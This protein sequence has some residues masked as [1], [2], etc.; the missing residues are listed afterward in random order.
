M[1]VSLR[2]RWDTSRLQAAIRATGVRPEA[3]F[4]SPSECS[5]PTICDIS[6]Q[7]VYANDHVSSRLQ[8]IQPYGSC[9]RCYGGK[10]Q[11]CE[12]QT[13]E[14][15]ISRSPNEGFSSATRNLSWQSVC[16]LYIKSIG[17]KLHA[18]SRWCLGCTVQA[19][20]AQT[21]GNHPWTSPI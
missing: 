11:A 13:S 19:C 9:R 3:Q 18:G 10:A 1:I 5:F 21:L 12:A 16:Y 14:R 17:S 8:K 4:E 6:G 2:D 15:I 20:E 7:S